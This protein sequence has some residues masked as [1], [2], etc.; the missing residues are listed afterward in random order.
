[1][2]K[3]MLSLFS[4]ILLMTL[5]SAPAG[6]NNSMICAAQA[7]PP[8]K[9]LE[10][11]PLAECRANGT[12]PT[13]RVTHWTSGRCEN[14]FC[15]L[16]PLLTGPGGEVAPSDTIWVYTIVEE[17]IGG[18]RIPVCELTASQAA[19]F[20]DINVKDCKPGSAYLH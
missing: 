3:S 15:E 17:V 20:P 1:M 16:V 11:P 8:Q 7:I 12:N 6:A 19:K 5:I 13:T 10:G 14:N 18:K 9:P 4:T 2:I